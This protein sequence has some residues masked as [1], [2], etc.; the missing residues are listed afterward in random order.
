M[1]LRHRLEDYSIKLQAINGLKN[2]YIVL[3]MSNTNEFVW[4]SVK[5]FFED[6]IEMQNGILVPYASL[7]GYCYPPAEIVEKMRAKESGIDLNKKIIGL[8]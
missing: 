5:D 4:L 6:H 1:T 8:N 7:T 3:F 2:K